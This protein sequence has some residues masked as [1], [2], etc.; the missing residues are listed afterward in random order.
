MIKFYPY[1]LKLIIFPTMNRELYYNMIYHSSSDFPN[2]TTGDLSFHECIMLGKFAIHDYMP[3][4]KTFYNMFIRTILKYS[5]KPNAEAKIFKE[6]LNLDVDSINTQNFKIFEKVIEVIKYIL[7]NFND[8]HKKLLE[9]HNFNKKF[10]RLIT[11][12]ANEDKTIDLPKIF[13]KKS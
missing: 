1:T 3:H 12:L 6:Y 8:I 7:V 2:Y 9:E 5:S 11:Y 13:D 4:K 10:K